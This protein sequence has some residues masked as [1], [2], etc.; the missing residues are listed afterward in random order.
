LNRILQINFIILFLLISS[1]IK[2][3]A[4]ENL[5]EFLTVHP[6]KKT[7]ALDSTAYPAKLIFTPVVSYAPETNLSFGLGMKGLFKL[8]GSGDETRT[9]N[10]PLTVQYSVENK[11]LFFS[12]F[13]IFWPQERYVLTG[14]V[15]VQSFPSLF[16]GVGQ[17][18]PKSNQEEFGFSRLL[19]EPIFLK[20]M[21]IPYLY[22]GGGLRY[23]RISN[24]DFISDGLLANSLQTGALGSTSVG[25]QLAAIYDS[26]DNLLN[27]KNG[28][29]L[30]LT[31]GFYGKL[32]GGTHDF[33]LTRLDMR[34]Y[35][36]PF[37][38]SNS[39][40]AFQFTM[41]FSH[42]DTPLQELGRLGG[43]ES[44][45]GYFEGR[46]TDR[47]LFVTQ[48][49]WRQKISRL[50]GVTAFTGVGSV[51]S[52]IGQFDISSLRPAVGVGVRFL[53]DPEE[54]LNLRLDFGAGQE[55]INY[56]FKIAEAF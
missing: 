19:V 23:N 27:A 17:D 10:I 34:Y 8:N 35:T 31:H 22:F 45:R 2:A 36:Q 42:G 55:K 38:K 30:R 12:G 16:F 21:F 13:D 44:L 6:N 29:Y 46:Y 48:V 41:H 1:G 37:K 18:S 43:S 49:E 25:G 11:Y 24:V 53:I 52:S 15:R 4:F 50:W 33:E 39:V 51:A 54:D 40:L 20:N 3:Q 32:L 47:N 9:S 56:Y 28:V 14:N 5:V 7:V 26:R